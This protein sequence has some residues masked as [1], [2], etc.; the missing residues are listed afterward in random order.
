MNFLDAVI[1]G[2]VEGVTEFLPV[3][4]TGHLI[5]VGHFIG[6]PNSEFLKTFEIAIQ[7]GAI[8]SVAV[9]YF[10]SLF[11]NRSIMLRIAVAFAPTAVLGALLYKVVKTVFLESN[12][13][14]AWSLLIGGVAIIL[15]EWRNRRIAEAKESKNQKSADSPTLAEEVTLQKS[16]WIGVFQSLAMIPGVSRSGATIIGGMALGVSRK[17]IVEFSFLLAFPT[18][19]A[20]TTLDLWKSRTI[21]NL[22]NLSLLAV[23]LVVSFL[24]AWVAIKFFLNFIQRNTFTVFGVYRIAAGILLLLFFL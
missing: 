19:L 1:L 7:L 13:L 21:F 2:V 9:I 14:I 11:A 6:L 16:F 15:F 18:M 5:L 17:N 20:A 10:K 4:S 22:D 12:Q 24:V 8:L 3:S 23:G